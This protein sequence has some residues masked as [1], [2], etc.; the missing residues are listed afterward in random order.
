MG[1]EFNELFDQWAHTYDSFVQGEDIQYK[2]VFARYEEI[3]E[4]VVN[5]SF[6]NVL[7]FGV[8]TGN[9][10]NRLLAAGRTV[11]G[12]EPSKEMRTIAKQKLPKEVAITEGDF[13]NFVTLS[14]VDTIVS[15]YAFHHLLDEEKNVAIAKYGQLLNKG[16]KIVFADTIF[17]DQDAYD[18]TIEA[19]QQ[20]GFYELAN[21]LQTEY[22]TRIPVM[23]S[24][25]E[26]NGFHVSFTRMNHYVWVMEATKQ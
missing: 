1:T 21:D 13:L 5:K 17:V 20:R 22:Y 4:D 18:K 23:Q 12:I 24:I 7:E 26:N 2:E 11:Y 14:H 6:G 8:G 15:T 9:L 10:T 16:G 3:L 19:A 25:F